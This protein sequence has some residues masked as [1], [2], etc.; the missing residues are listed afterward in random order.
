M[1]PGSDLA[2]SQR[3]AA[4][5]LLHLIGEARAH[6]L[7][8]SATLERGVCATGRLDVVNRGALRIGPRVT[9]RGGMIPSKIL[10]HPGAEVHIGAESF[11]NYGALIDVAARLVIGKRCVL[12]SMVE[13]KCTGSG[14]VVGDEVW[15]GHGAIIGSGVTIG[16][17]SVVAAGCVVTEDVPADTLA[18]GAPARLVCLHMPEVPQRVLASRASLAP[19]RDQAAGC[20]LKPDGKGNQHDTPAAAPMHSRDGLRRGAH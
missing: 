6:W 5:R 16:A 15:I 12:A 17:R 1:T 13:L 14:V 8:R 11:F 10:V 2:V 19:G 9:F 20:H 3:P 4:M 18:V 7:L